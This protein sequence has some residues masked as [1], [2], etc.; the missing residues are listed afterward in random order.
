MILPFN[1]ILKNNQQKNSIFTST[2]N[3]NSNNL[4]NPHYV[5]GLTDGDGCFYFCI[6]PN[7]TKIGWGVKV[8]F[9]L[10]AYNNSA[11]LNMLLKIKEYFG[12]GKIILQKESNI[13]YYYVGSL[14]DCLKIREHFFKYPLLTYKL[15][16]FQIW[17][18]IINLM[19]TK[20][21]LTN[22]G[23][24]KIVSYKEH[25]PFGISDLLKEAFP[26]YTPINIMN[27]SPNLLLLNIHWLAGFIN[28]DGSFGVY[29]NKS[30]SNKLKKQCSP[31]ITISQHTRSLLVLNAIKELLGIGKI[32]H[33]Y[34]RKASQLTI[35]KLTE[36]NKF[37]E[38]FSEAQLLGAKALDYN[39]FS[40]CIDLINNKAH[41]TEE[42][43]NSIKEITKSMN[44]LRTKFN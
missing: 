11:N 17:S 1:F 39:D 42:G 20:D 21:H 29:F 41:L 4:L 18:E 30:I 15:V 23:I 32:Y 12:V 28:A 6:T 27:Y 37:I 33:Q 31:R 8:G 7:T 22:E 14:K 16:H 9:K 24:L 13:L 43:S 38:L 5:T 40:K 3:Y 2:L 36:I 19:L 26:N 44:T 35:Q 10:V 25:S 34:Q